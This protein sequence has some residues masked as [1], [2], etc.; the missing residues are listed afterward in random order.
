MSYLQGKAKA[1]E[2]AISWQMEFDGKCLSWHELAITHSH[3]ER[4]A[5]RFGLV[6]EFRE[7]GI[8]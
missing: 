3:F 6:N 1:R 8:I 4:L 7:N 2:E 5:K